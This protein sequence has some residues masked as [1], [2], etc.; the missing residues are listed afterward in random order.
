MTGP[1][2]PARQ[3]STRTG[4][5]G[6]ASTGR[7][8]TGRESTGSGDL[9]DRVMR[10]AHLIRRASADGLAPLHLT[11]AQSRALR[12]I[13]RADGPLRMGELAAFLGVVPRSATG[14][15]DPLEASGLVARAVDPDN[16]RSVL[17]T[18]TDRGVEIQREMA[19]ARKAAADRM[20]GELTAAERAE[21][22]RLLD[23]VLPDG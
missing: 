23:R 8:S 19:A 2:S 12:V 13:A 20:F 9:T 15:V 7:A 18:L 11:P 21:L 1:E 4:S 22:S 6:R 17:V 10:L 16:R 3:K 14:L 5:P